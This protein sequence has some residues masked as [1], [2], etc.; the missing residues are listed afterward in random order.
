MHQFLKSWKHP[1]ADVLLKSPMLS[2][3]L[4]GCAQFTVK[5]FLF[6][7][8]VL[9]IVCTK[10]FFIND[11]LFF[12]FFELCFIFFKLLFIRFVLNSSILVVSDP[13]VVVVTVHDD[14]VNCKFLIILDD[15]FKFIE[16]IYKFRIMTILT[17]S[18]KRT[19]FPIF[20]R[21][22]RLLGFE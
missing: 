21:L 15:A 8:V 5:L 11:H 19:M 10:L 6:F 13:Y 3:Q 17:N 20:V 16:N 9:S 18:N 4:F 14:I 1:L 12:V 7:S 2:K 22:K